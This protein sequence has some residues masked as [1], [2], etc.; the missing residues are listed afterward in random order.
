MFEPQKY[1][2]VAVDFGPE[3]GDTTDEDGDVE[4]ERSGIDEL[5]GRERDRCVRGR[6][7][8]DNIVEDGRVQL[9]GC[10]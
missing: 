9:R 7:L 10:R 8:T 4:R 1:R 3:R 2:A 6:L 5:R